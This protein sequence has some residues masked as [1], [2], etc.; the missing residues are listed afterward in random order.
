MK[1][2]ERKTEAL[3]KRL[4]IFKPK[5][6]PQYKEKIPESFIEEAADRYVI[7]SKMVTKPHVTFYAYLSLVWYNYQ[8][9]GSMIDYQAEKEVLI[10]KKKGK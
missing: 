9:T 6:K 10:K 5:R 1:L 2:I 8:Q 4:A 7:L 3:I